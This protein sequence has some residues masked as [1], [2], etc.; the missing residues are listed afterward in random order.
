[1]LNADPAFFPRPVSGMIP[2]SMVDLHSHI[3]PGT[4]DGAVS[5]ED[6]VEMCHQA[7]ADGA[8]TMVATPHRFDGVHDNPPVEVLRDRLA[9]L[10]RAVGDRIRLVLGCE[11]RF[12]HGI[13]EQLVETREA[14]PINDGPYVLI[15]FPPFA[16]PAGCER[17]IY[18]IASAGYVPLIAH[19]ERNRTVQE[20]PERFYNL[21]E[22]GLYGQIDAASLLG[23]FGK[24][25]EAT[26]RLLLECNLG[27]AISSDTHS[28]RRRRPG[29]SKACEVAKGIVGEE[30]AASL[31]DANPRAVVEGRPLP[32]APEPTVPRAKRSRWYIF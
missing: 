17:A 29:L 18:Q 9:E 30:A 7:A 13:V 12:T 31:V 26:A 21:A 23:K 27:H 25:A 5:L 22:L 32:H 8:D 1:M 4:D 11:L 14:L 2:G 16:L 3:L 6:A 10:Q 20:K 28:P 19:P 24:E 15:E